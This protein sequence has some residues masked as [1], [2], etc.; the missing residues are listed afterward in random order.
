MKCRKCG[1]TAIINLRHHN[2]AYCAEHFKEYFEKRVEM[3]I[4]KYS[5]FSRKDKILVAVSGGKDSTTV[6]FVLAKLGYKVSGMNIDVGTVPADVNKLKDFASSIGSELITV[7]SR[8]LLE[9][10]TV[11]EAAKIVKR[12][13]C[14]VCGSVRRYIMN[15]VA[16]ENGFTV[17]VTGHNLDDEASFLLGNLL[18][19]NLDY[20]RRQK[21]VLPATEEGFSKKAKPLVLLTE[22]ETF[23]Y[24]FINNLPFSEEICPYSK[25]ATSLH[26]KHMLNEIELKHPGTKLRFYDGFQ[27]ANLFE[28]NMVVELKKCNVCGYPT[29]TDVCS[30]C[31]MKER[32]KSAVGEQK[33]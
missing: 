18:N 16:S 15:K 10:L 25:E 5:M 21:P 31:R 14:S 4:K 26:Y 19:W 8:E 17:L 3:T 6:W 11:P 29:T 12:P 1:K 7:D 28:D 23:T 32:L 27:K 30:F 20:L 13:V 22:K 2:V 24:A 9:G 33:V